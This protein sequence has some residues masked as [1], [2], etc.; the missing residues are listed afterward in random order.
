LIDSGFPESGITYIGNP[1]NCCVHGYHGSYNP[2]PGHHTYAF[3]NWI[4]AGVVANGN[5]DVY[6]MSHEVSEWVLQG[7]LEHAQHHLLST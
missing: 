6:T 4:A 7:L 2:A 3:A 1:S 5:A